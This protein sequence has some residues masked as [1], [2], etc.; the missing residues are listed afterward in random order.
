[1]KL[2]PS[3]V[4]KRLKEGIEFDALGAAESSAQALINDAAIVLEQLLGEVDPTWNIPKY[5]ANFGDEKVCTCGHSYYRHF[6]TY[7][8]MAP[9]GC[10]YCDCHVFEE[11]PKSA[12]G[13]GFERHGKVL[14]ARQNFRFARYSTVDGLATIY[15]GDG[16]E[17]DEKDCITVSLDSLRDDY[18]K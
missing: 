5:D 16:H 12:G 18:D 15:A 3:D 14:F 2:I 10:K 11:R 4:L 1:M 6:D 13:Y 17:C 7:E 9:I 8:D